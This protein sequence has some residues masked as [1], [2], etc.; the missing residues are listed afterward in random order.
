MDSNGDTKSCSVET[1]NKWSKASDFPIINPLFSG[2]KNR[3][4]YAATTSGSRKNLPHFPFDTVVKLNVVT[5]ST[6]TWSAGSRCF[7]GEPIF[8]PKTTVQS[9]HDQQ[10][11]DDGYLLVVEVRILYMAQSTKLLSFWYFFF[12]F[13]FI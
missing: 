1:L 10:Q 11:E 9:H 2:K 8:V 12:F 13:F 5:K 6:T 4:I 7:I 3:Y